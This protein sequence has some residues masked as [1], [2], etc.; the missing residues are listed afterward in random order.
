MERVNGHLPL[1]LLLKNVSSNGPGATALQALD[2]KVHQV[3]LSADVT[4]DFSKHH[5]K[6]GDPPPPV[7]II[8]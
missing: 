3:S 4:S 8:I 1:P 2:C 7:S 6:Y 5:A